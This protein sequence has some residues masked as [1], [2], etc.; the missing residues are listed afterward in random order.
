[1]RFSS[2]DLA[3]T[4]PPAIVGR[5]GRRVELENADRRARRPVD[6]PVGQNTPNPVNP[7][8]QKYS[9]LQKTRN[10]SIFPTIPSHQEGRVAIV[11]FAGR[12]AVDAK[13]A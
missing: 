5:K 3:M 9:D 12:A 7:L 2:A 13:G 8:L 6:V 11:T 10:G 4:M 1:M